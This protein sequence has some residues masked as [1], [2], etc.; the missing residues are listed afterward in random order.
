MKYQN[1]LIN[2]L[3]LGSLCLAPSA[4]AG[5]SQLAHALEQAQA[6]Q[7]SYQAQAT[8]EASA[9][10]RAALGH[11]EILRRDHKTDKRLKTA[12]ADLKSS[13][14]QNKSEAYEKSAR[15]LDLALKQLEQ[16][17]AGE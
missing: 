8:E 1:L 15:A 2:T 14:K 5:T 13:L 3:L 4:W 17:K 10:T 16:F 9:H 12:E 6:A 7:S 11:V